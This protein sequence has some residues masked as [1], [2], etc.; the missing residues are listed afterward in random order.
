MGKKKTY[1]KQKCGRLKNKIHTEVSVMFV[2]EIDVY[3]KIE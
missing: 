2:F 1:R 3:F